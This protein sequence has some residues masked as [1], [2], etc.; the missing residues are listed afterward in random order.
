MEHIGMDVHKKERQLCILTEAGEL[1]ERRIHTE[2]QRGG[3]APTGGRGRGAAH[4]PRG[5]RRAHSPAAAARAEAAAL[6]REGQ[7][8]LQSAGVTPEAGE[9]VGEDSTGEELAELLFHEPRQA[10][11]LGAVGRFAEKGLQ[12]GADHG[13]ENAA[14]RVAGAVGR[15]REG[16]GPHVRSERGPG[17]CPKRNTPRRWGPM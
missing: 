9:A 15:A 16:H 11:P 5:A 6:A 1:I 8:P 2:P 17:Q 4:H 14:L 12:V 7:Q 3:S 10:G 13:V